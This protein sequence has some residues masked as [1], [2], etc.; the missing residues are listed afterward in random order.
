MAQIIYEVSTKGK[1]I[2][3]VTE[4]EEIPTPEKVRMDLTAMLA[5]W[6]D[7]NNASCECTITVS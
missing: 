4:Q 3:D 2:Y 5:T 6:S 7:E 1:V